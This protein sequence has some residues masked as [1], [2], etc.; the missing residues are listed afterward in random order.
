MDN[1]TTQNE[2]N[3]EG[4][5]IMDKKERITFLREEIDKFKQRQETEA[6]LWEEHRQLVEQ[7]DYLYMVEYPAEIEK[8]KKLYREGKVSR[9]EHRSNLSVCIGKY[10]K[11]KTDLYKR[12]WKAFG[13]ADFARD[14]ARLG[15]WREDKYRSEL[16][17]LESEVLKNV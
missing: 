12:K 9:S 15:S 8:L 4:E 1:K 3:F 5:N 14:M 17:R 2:I 16:E 7:E 13:K 11:K 10:R 6:K